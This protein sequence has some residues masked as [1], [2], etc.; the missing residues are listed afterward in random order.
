MLLP[1]FLEKAKNLESIA[2]ADT[3][4]IIN[5]NYQYQPCEFSNGLHEDLLVNLAGTNEGSCRIFAFS[6]IYQ[7]NQQQTL[8]L[9]GDY[10][11]IDVLGNPDGNDHLN[12]RNFI[13]YSWEGIDFKGQALVTIN[14]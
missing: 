11:H 1:V 8:N 14:E 2:F 3:I 4:S 12:I 13:K 6:K 9:F 10:Y 7:L 5:E